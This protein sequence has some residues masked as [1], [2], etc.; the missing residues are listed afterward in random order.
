LFLSD[1]SGRNSLWAVPIE[2][3]RP[4]GQPT[5]IRNDV[6]PISVLG[7]TKAGALY[8]SL[9]ASIRSNVFM[10]EL[11]G[12]RTLSAPVLVSERP[13]NRNLGSAWSPDGESLAYFS[14][15]DTGSP[16]LV[17]RSA[18]TGVERSVRMPDRL[19]SR[20]GAGPKWFPDNRSVLVEAA[21]A[22]GAGFSLYKVSLATGNTELLA[23]LQGE[24]YSYDLSADGRT[25]FYAIGSAQESEQKVIRLDVQT[26][27]A[28]ELRTISFPDTR[29]IMAL[30]VSPDRTRLAMTLQGGV[31]Q[32]MPAEGGQTHVLWTPEKPEGGGQLRQAL[33]WT[34]DGRFLLFARGDGLLWK[35]PVA[36]GPAEKV[37]D[38][39][40]VQ[41]PSLHPDG[42]RL[43]FTSVGSPGAFSNARNSRS[44]WVIDRVLG[45]R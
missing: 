38:Y 43:L 45:S 20:F 18:R 40:Y 3:G 6:G 1:R 11:D 14:L 27:V 23:R 29:E 12:L 31:V 30:A 4:G 32:I 8:Y 36:G 41:S 21:D 28:T 10:A 2:G 33:S 19:S 7:L 13:I 42:K 22:Q 44:V 25:I 39:E 16:V 37:L 9:P 5:L 26:R 34:R 35:A 15:P 24:V 17:V